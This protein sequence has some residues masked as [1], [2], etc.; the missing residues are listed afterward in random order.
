MAEMIED[1][2]RATALRAAGKAA[3]RCSRAVCARV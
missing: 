3:V 1:A 2:M